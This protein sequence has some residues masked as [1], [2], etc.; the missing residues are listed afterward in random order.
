MDK[1]ELRSEQFDFFKISNDEFAVT[2][3]KY[4]NVD[5]YSTNKKSQWQSKSRVV[6]KEINGEL[7]IISET[8]DFTYYT[9]K[10]F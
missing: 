2:F 10:N 1:I 3:D 9:N 7:R 8:D 4:F 5:N 6:F